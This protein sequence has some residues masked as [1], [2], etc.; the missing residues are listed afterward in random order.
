MSHT[1]GYPARVTLGALGGTDLAARFG[2][3]WDGAHYGVA[4]DEIRDGAPHVFFHSIG[5]RLE[6]SAQAVML[7]APGEPSTSPSLL[8]NVPGVFFAAW[9]VEHA[10]ESRVRVASFDS[11]G[12]PLGEPVI[13]QG[14]DGRARSP[15]LAGGDR[16]LGLTTVTA[17]GVSFHRVLLGPCP[18]RR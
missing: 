4:W 12:A 8:S 15:T 3:A 2:V 7:S 11:E 5:A 9:E 6:S 10:N 16:A 1:R 18:I 17:R 14:H 13:V